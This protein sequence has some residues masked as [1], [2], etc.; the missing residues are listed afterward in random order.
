[1][2]WGAVRIRPGRHYCPEHG[3]VRPHHELVPAC[4]QCGRGAHVGARTPEG[5][6]TREVIPSTCG[7]EPPH[8]L[9]PLTVLLGTRACGC[10][11]DGMHRTWTCRECGD[12]REWPRHDETRVPPFYGPG[13]GQSLRSM[14]GG[15]GQSG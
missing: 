9:G 4:P 14:R 12:V 10:A 11:P 5:V 15:S 8:R 6:Q 1:M 2:N 7:G 13:S 3:E